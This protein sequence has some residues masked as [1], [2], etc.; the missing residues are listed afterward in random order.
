[1]MLTLL[2]FFIYLDISVIYGFHI[3]P[4]SPPSPH[5]PSARI[6]M[7]I[8]PFKRPRIH[9]A[10]GNLYVDESCIDCDVCRWMCPSVYERKGVLSSVKRQPTSEPEKLIA[11]SAIVACP[12]GA[13]RLHEPDD[14]MKKVI[15][16]FPAEIDP[17]HLPGV[18]HLGYHSK[19]SYGATSY[20]IRS[21]ASN[22]TIM[23]DVPRYN[24]RLVM[25]SNPQCQAH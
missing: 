25:L 6:F 14:V 9:N 7:D 4:Q 20:L 1:M 13:I 3:H 15:S 18:Y 17:E 5:R 10:P 23:I 11:Y 2:S 12:V 19:E 24:S 8:A 21:Q 22:M 16:I